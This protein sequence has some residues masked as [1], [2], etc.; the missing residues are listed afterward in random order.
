MKKKKRM[1]LQLLSLFKH[2]F[3]CTTH[4]TRKVGG[5]TTQKAEGDTAQKPKSKPK[6]HHVHSGH[7]RL[8]ECSHL[9]SGKRSGFQF[10]TING[11]SP[12]R[13]SY[14]EHV[15]HCFAEKLLST[16]RCMPVAGMHSFKYEEVCQ[17]CII[18]QQ[19]KFWLMDLHQGADRAPHEV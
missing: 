14:H 15:H 2:S 10:H 12:T 4:F 3:F 18:N 1:I 13:S 17:T 5:E 8:T 7:L 19:K 6:P 16:K 11:K 9:K